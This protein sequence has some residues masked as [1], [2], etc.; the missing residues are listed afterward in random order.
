MRQLPDRLLIAFILLLSLPA[1]NSGSCLSA[2]HH[3]EWLENRKALKSVFLLIPEIEEEFEGE[4]K[5]I[6]NPA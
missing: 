6:F 3:C 5:D 1:F 2:L 4:K